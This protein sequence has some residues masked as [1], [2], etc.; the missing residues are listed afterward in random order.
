[1][2]PLAVIVLRRNAAIVCRR[3]RSP[4]GITR[5]RHSCL[6]ERTNRSAYAFAFGA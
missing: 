2:I 3:W 5:L 4:S 1:M 6:L